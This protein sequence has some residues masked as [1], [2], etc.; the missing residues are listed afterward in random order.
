MRKVF[1]I[2]LCVVPITLAFAS[3]QLMADDHDGLRFRGPN[4][5]AIPITNL[6]PPIPVPQVTSGVGGAGAVILPQFAANGAWASEIVITNTSNAAI[7]AR[8]D[9][10]KPDGTALTTK[11]NGQSASSFTNLMIAAGGVLV[12]APRDNDGDDDF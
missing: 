5:S 2:L 11:L 4:F 6:S 7:M 8:V 1:H 3:V 10:F 12:L 9:L